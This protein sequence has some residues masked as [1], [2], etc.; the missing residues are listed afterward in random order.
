MADALRLD[1][2]AALNKR[3]IVDVQPENGGGGGSKTAP[4]TPT[5][6]AIAIPKFASKLELP[7]QTKP[8]SY[9]VSNKAPSSPT[10]IVPSPF[11][12]PVN[13]ILAYFLVVGPDW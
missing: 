1:L 12:L 13:F 9:T 10:G 5:S 7:S 2:P 6:E 4:C 8:F 11:Y 3:L